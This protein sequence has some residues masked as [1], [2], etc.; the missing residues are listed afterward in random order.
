MKNLVQTDV[1]AMWTTWGQ[2]EPFNA[3]Y[4]AVGTGETKYSPE[5]VRYTQNYTHIPTELKLPFGLIIHG[6]ISQ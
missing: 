6:V 4:G 3:S 5:S 1:D 2:S